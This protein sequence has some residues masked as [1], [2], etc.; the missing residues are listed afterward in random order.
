[1]EVIAS[2]QSIKVPAEI[3]VCRIC[4]AEIVLDID[5]WEE[6]DDGQWMASE[7][8]V[9]CNCVTEP[10]I[11]HENYEWHTWFYHHWLMPY[12]DWLPIDMKVHEWLSENYRFI[13]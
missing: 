1:M 12:V 7:A 6:D 2:S 9:H 10:D 8:G 11:S 13:L 4:G 5:E 3:A